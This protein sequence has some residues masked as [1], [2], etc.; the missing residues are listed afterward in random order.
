[1]HVS[2]TTR[3]ILTTALAVVLTVGGLGACSTGDR[4]NTVAA[5]PAPP[6]EVANL[7]T[8]CLDFLDGSRTAAFTVKGTGVPKD[9]GKSRM[10]SGKGVM[11]R[12]TPSTAAFDGDLKVLISGSEVPVSVISFR[13]RLYVRTGEN[14]AWQVS[15]P[16]A[17]GMIDPATW[18]EREKGIPRMLTELKSVQD[19]GTSTLD[20]GTVVH[21]VKGYI[22][23]YLAAR[24]IPIADV[25]SRVQI[26]LSIDPKTYELRRAVMTGHFFESA[27]SSS[28]VVRLFDYDEKVVIKPPKV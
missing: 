25:N 24:L 3:S 1:M 16:G 21:D 5:E 26:T 6:P 2:R 28:Y 15:D 8:R 10:I 18:I 12:P 23:G 11:S 17:F 27:P 13:G 14:A 9:A 19:G 4:S 7:L 20:D 22:T